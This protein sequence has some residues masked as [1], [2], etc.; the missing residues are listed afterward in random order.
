M[1]AALINPFINATLNVLKTMA[2]VT[3]RPGRP[4]LKKDNLP[5]GDVTGVIGL[6]G[7]VRGTVAL[8]FKAESICAIVSNMLGEEISTLD[9][10]VSDAVG[11][12]TSMISGQARKE[13]EGQ[14]QVL[15]AVVPEVLSGRH[16]PVMQQVEGASIAIPFSTRGGN[17]SIEVCFEE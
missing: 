9:K 4:Y 15:E 8:T 7:A 13:L 16:H 5:T 17:F 12:L 6:T 1:D 11:E 10:D 2:N 14:G 3:C